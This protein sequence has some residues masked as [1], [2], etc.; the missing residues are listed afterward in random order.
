MISNTL[1]LLTWKHVYVFQGSYSAGYRGALN[2]RIA[3]VDREHPFWLMVVPN[4]EHTRATVSTESLGRKWDHLHERTAVMGA[5]EKAGI[6]QD[7]RLQQQD[8]ASFD[9]ETLNIYPG[10]QEA[11]SL[12]LVFLEVYTNPPNLAIKCQSSQKRAERIQLGMH[13]P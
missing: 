8:T 3:K 2:G 4:G 11:S 5:C 6:C 12:A 9:I 13:A 10:T 7:I 1:F